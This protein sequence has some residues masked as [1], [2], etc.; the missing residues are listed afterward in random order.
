MRDSLIIAP[1]ILSADW[2]CLREEVGVVMR[3]GADWIHV[4]VMDGHFVPPLTFGPDFV[5]CLRK[6]V[7]GKNELPGRPF[8]DVHLMIERPELQVE[9]FA[10]AGSDLITIHFEACPHIHRVIQSIKQLGVKVGVAL[11]P[12]TNVSVL[13]PIIE[14]LDLILIMT[15]NPGWGGQ[16]FINASL[17]KI[18]QASNLIEAS[19][20]DI[21]L[22]VDGGINEQTAKLVRDAGANVI[23]AGSYVFNSNNYIEAINSLRG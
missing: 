12:G 18:R 23:V 20:L 2:G 16:R 6:P 8:L 5:A 15:V 13:E 21:A 19:G 17:Q 11:N 4:D 7:A 3:A 10:R 1:S 14:E 9:S 22:E